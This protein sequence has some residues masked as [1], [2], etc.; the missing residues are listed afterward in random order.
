MAQEIKTE[1]YKNIEVDK[2]GNLILT[3]DQ[4]IELANYISKIEADRDKYKA[5]YEQAMIELEKAYERGN[6]D[7]NITGKILTGA[8]IAALILIL[9]GSTK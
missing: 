2:E 8:G 7:I 5:M 4:Y 3:P 9:A 6:N 1:K